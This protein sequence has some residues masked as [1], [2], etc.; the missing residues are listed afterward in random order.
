M[1]D[2]FLS[3]AAV[4]RMW[5]RRAVQ[6]LHLDLERGVAARLLALNAHAHAEAEAELLQPRVH[7]LLVHALCHLVGHDHET[8]AQTAA[9]VQAEEEVCVGLGLPPL[10]P[11][12]VVE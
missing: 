3:P 11:A 5:S 9:M 7:L 10:G 2:I 6:Q 12:A 8:A 4:Q 1:G